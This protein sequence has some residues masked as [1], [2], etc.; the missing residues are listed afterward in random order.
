[1]SVQWKSFGSMNQSAT[2]FDELQIVFYVNR[3]PRTV[4]ASSPEH[5]Y[6]LAGFSWVNNEV[7]V[8]TLTF[9]S[10]YTKVPWSNWQLPSSLVKLDMQ[11]HNFKFQVSIVVGNLKTTIWNS[12][13]HFFKT[14][15]HTPTP[16]P[17][18]G[19]TLYTHLGCPGTC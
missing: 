9:G 10:L 7:A 4:Q 17:R 13:Y 11:I 2:V 12:F 3:T 18:A 19:L 14:N 15:F 8:R 5:Q 16:K 1:M 6:L